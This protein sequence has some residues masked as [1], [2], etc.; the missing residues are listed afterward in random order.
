MRTYDLSPLFRSAI[1]FDRLANTLESIHN[2]NS[3]GGYPPYN[4]ELVDENQYT[5]TMAVAGFTADDLEIEVEQNKLRVTGQKNEDDNERQ[6]LH[7]GIANRNFERSF[8]LADHIK[9]A[10]AT[11][12][13]G[14]L[15]LELVREIPEAM[16]P[17]RIE[18]QKRANSVLENKV[19]AA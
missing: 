17:R 16:K 18:I 5:I 3:S 11:I 4:I 13:D 19:E 12:Q 7:R 14:M 15:Y 10:N 9:V 1:G 8:Q 2:T 6:Y